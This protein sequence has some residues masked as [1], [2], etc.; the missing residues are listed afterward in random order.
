MTYIF[1]NLDSNATFDDFRRE[2]ENHF[3][4]DYYAS[5]EPEDIPC[6]K[7]ADANNAWVRYDYSIG[8]ITLWIDDSDDAEIIVE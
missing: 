1:K 8:N 4:E 6:G 7:I 2:Y 5:S 3:G